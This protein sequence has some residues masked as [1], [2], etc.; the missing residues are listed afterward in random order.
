[1]RACSPVPLPVCPPTCPRTPLP[2]SR[3]CAPSLSGGLDV[4]A[5][6]TPMQ[7]RRYEKFRRSA[8]ARAKLKRV[9][10]TPAPHPARPVAAA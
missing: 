6:F 4:T 10:A 8:F 2:S 5:D 7:L 9:R 1:M 3:C